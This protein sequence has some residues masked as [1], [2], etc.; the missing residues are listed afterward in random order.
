MYLGL[1]NIPSNLK[2]IIPSTILNTEPNENECDKT[3]VDKMIQKIKDG[4]PHIKKIKA[5][6]TSDVEKGLAR[7]ELTNLFDELW[8]SFKNCV[9]LKEIT[10]WLCILDLNRIRDDMEYMNRIIRPQLLKNVGD[11]NTKLDEI[12]NSIG[13]RYIGYRASRLLH[14]TALSAGLRRLFMYE[15][16]PYVSIDMDSE[17]MLAYDPLMKHMVRFPSSTAARYLLPFSM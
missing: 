3:M 10:L 14:R 15:N 11:K 2:S 13:F 5:W 9:E 1:T 16:S 17:F 6:A 4:Q 8:I 12:K 7:T